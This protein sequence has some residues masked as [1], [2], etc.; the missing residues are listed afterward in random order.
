MG[1][2]CIS[3]V[4]QQHIRNPPMNQTLS[5]H[6]TTPSERDID[7]FQYNLIGI[8]EDIVIPEFCSA[9]R[10]GESSRY[11]SLE[12]AD[13]CLVAKGSSGSTGIRTL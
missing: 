1:S 10:S 5:E 3:A 6:S 2:E 11:S 9:Q 8:K 13:G 7:G 12:L 4:S